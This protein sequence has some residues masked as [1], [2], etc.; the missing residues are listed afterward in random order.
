MNDNQLKEI[1]TYST[2]EKRIQIT[3]KYKKT[4]C[5]KKGEQ[6]VRNEELNGIEKQIL[7]L[8]RKQY[9]LYL[10]RGWHIIKKIETNIRDKK[11]HVFNKQKSVFK[12]EI[13]EDTKCV[14]NW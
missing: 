4:L 8:V 14:V 11:G 10:E 7:P 2:S 9:T 1:T 3:G 12:K 6:Q 5:R 13:T